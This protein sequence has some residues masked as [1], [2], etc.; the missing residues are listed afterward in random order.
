M[1]VRMRR[2][3]PVVLVVVMFL[4]CLGVHAMDAEKAVGEVLYHQDF[5]A[6]S[7]FAESGIR[8][9]TAS[10][11]NAIVVCPEQSLEIFT[12]DTGR[13]HVLLPEADKGDGDS[14]TIE[15]TFRFTAVHSENGFIAPI[16][17]CRGCEPSN[18]TSIIIRADGSV[19][20]FSEPDENLKNAIAAGETIGVKIPV[21][22]GV[23]HEVIFSAGGVEYTV[24]RENVLMINNGTVGFTVRNADVAI[25]E[26]FVV[27]GTDYAEKSGYYTEQ[28]YASDD[29]PITV[30]ECSEESDEL[31]PDTGDFP[32]VLAVVI[33]AAAFGGG[34][35]CAFISRKRRM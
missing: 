27:N 26:V 28:S 17:T 9:G 31:S 13:V 2:L 33:A 22:G 1:G 11:S 5:S 10:A 3:V 15:F 30:P 29:S 7:D 19:D 25:D 18:I 12:Y 35:A 32:V 4:S 16:L 34:F 8:L 21:S 20:N 24:E 14:Y 6:V 23:M